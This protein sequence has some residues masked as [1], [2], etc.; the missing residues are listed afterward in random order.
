MSGVACDSALVCPWKMGETTGIYTNASGVALIPF[1][2][3]TQGSFS[4][5]VTKQNFIPYEGTA[6]VVLPTGPF[7]YK[8]AE[9]IDD[10]TAGLSFGNANYTVDAGETVELTLALRNNGGTTASAVTATVRTADPFITFTDSTASF[11]NIASKAFA[12]PDVPFLVEVSRECPDAHDAVCTVE[13]RDGQDS[14]WTDVFV[15]RVHAPRLWHASHVYFDTLASG[16]R[17]GYIN[18]GEEIELVLTLK[19]LGAGAGNTVRG[20][21]TSPSA[22]VTIYDSLTTFGSVEACSSSTGDEFMFV[23]STE[24][25]APVFQLTVTTRRPERVSTSG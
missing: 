22:F 10:D 4:V 7:L 18:A 16:N 6:Q 23:C 12:I 3:D 13:A 25:E 11:G 24:E 8:Y 14:V 2:P 21:L 19:N 9:D 20:K 17:D 1:N 5:T 15:V